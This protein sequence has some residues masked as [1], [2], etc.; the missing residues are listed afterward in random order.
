MIVRANLYR[1]PYTREEGPPKA[2][3][4]QVP[5]PP[6]QETGFA[7]ECD[8]KAQAMTLVRD[9]LKTFG[10][11]LRSISYSTDGAIVAVLYRR[12]PTTRPPL[13]RP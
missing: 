13:A 1:L 2:T 9:R 12:S 5:A 6:R 4:G 10:E 7:V 8:T 11:E 3:P